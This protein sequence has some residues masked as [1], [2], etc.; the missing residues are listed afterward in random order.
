MPRKFI[1]ADYE[2]TLDITIRLGD[3]IPSNHLA[4]FILDIIALLNLSAIYA[5]FGSRGAPPYAP[6]ILLA[7]LFYGYATGTFSSRK[8]EQAT[9]EALPFILIAGGMHP[10]H[11]TIANFRKKFLPEIKELFAKILLIACEV[12]VLKLGNVS[13]DGTKIHA[14]AS[15]SHAV[16]YARIPEIEAQ[17]NQEIEYLIDLGKQ[18]DNGIPLPEG[19][20]VNEEIIRRQERLENL[21]QAKD[22]I[23]KRAQ[24]RDKIEQDEYQAVLKERE[25]KE[26]VLG[27]KLPGRKPSPP[28]EGPRDKDQYN[29]T[30]PDSRIMKNSN[31][32][33]FDQHY[34]AQIAVEYDSSLIVGHSL[35]NHPNDQGE[36]KPTIDSIPS[37]LGMPEAASLDNGYFSETNVKLLEAY[38]IDPYIATGRVPHY[39]NLPEVAAN[40]VELQHTAQTEEQKNA[41]ISVVTEEACELTIEAITTD[42]ASIEALDTELPSEL[43]SSEIEDT[44]EVPSLE[45]E[46][47]TLDN[48]SIDTSDVELPIE[49]SSSEV[50][51]TEEV[52]SLEIEAVTTDN[53]SIDTDIEQA[54]E[55]SSNEVE[56][57]GSVSSQDKPSE[58]PSAKV[59][60]A[61]KLKTEAGKAIYRLRKCTVEPVIGIIKETIGFR[62]FSLRGL[63][64][65]AG[66]W[67]L[68]C[69]AF[70]LKRLH[71]LTGGEL[72]SSL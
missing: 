48:A 40:D 61:S 12:G 18:S 39:L 26:R 29:F 9:Y 53:A 62:Q 65:T 3:V 22:V 60:M 5:R 20:S 66:E 41:D 42:D 33:G 11:D 6:E 32:K 59:K 68:M 69:L 28:Q 47:I 4:F 21:A 56:G 44:E 71:V 50:E 64:A 67:S 14:D 54:K 52:S 43:S 55:Q 13:L 2:A 17:L 31:N 72:C 45:I 37:Q 10:D 8:I 70:N 30:D 23:E 57:I 19:I 7:L 16:S 63:E 24:E 51:D 36:I 25:E 38:G 46:A 27:R 1:T 15:K 58:E 49:L 34:N 35:S